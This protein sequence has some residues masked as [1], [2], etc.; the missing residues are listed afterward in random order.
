MRKERGP[1]HIIEMGFKRE[2]GSNNLKKG[3]RRHED[4]HIDSLG[5]PT[6]VFWQNG[7]GWVEKGVRPKKEGNSSLCGGIMGRLPIHSFLNNVSRGK[8]GQ[9]WSRT[10]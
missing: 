8:C 10:Y 1:R 3:K 9:K 6:L 7:I 2:R 4:G 5:S